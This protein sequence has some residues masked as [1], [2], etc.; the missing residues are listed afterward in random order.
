MMRKP[1]FF[2][3]GAPKCGTT[4]LAAWLGEHPNIYLPAKTPTTEPH[5]FSTDLNLPRIEER[6]EYDRLFRGATDSHIAVGEASTS[7]LFS[8]TAIASVEREFPEPKYIVMVRDP[9]KMARSLHEENV[10]RGAEHILSF[11]TA[12]RLSSE[13]REGRSVSRW[14]QEPRL[15]DYQLVCRLGEQVGRLLE[16]V[17]R[18]RILVIVLDDVAADTRREYLRTL[19]FL[20]V[21]YDGREDFP[22]KNAAKQHRSSSLRFATQV[23]GR[24]GAHAKS[25]L[26]IPASKRW[27]LLETVDRLNTSPWVRPP[28][29]ACLRSELLEYY[30]DDI[31]ELGR[32]LER[33]FTDWL[34]LD[35]PVP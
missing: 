29:S 11:E 34:G 24:A 35:C 17:P 26:G 18:E 23:L 13:R 5:F 20:G 7:Y 12:W 25:L 21:A 30:K 3:V 2:I 19:S 6:S 4:S 14:C 15:L 10:Y 16:A 31:K 32:L 27:G 8:R 33:D 1:D 22:V 28:V 9:A